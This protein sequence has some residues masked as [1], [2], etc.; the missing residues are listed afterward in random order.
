MRRKRSTG[1]AGP[2]SIAD[3]RNA[4]AIEGTEGMMEGKYRESVHA[5]GR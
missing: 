3:T 4:A 5:E 1:P 2:V